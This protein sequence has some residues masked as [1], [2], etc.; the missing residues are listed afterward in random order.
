[1]FN[2]NKYTQLQD[3]KNIFNHV[4][5][6]KY[7]MRVLPNTYTVCG[8]NFCTHICP[9]PWKNKDEILLSILSMYTY[10]TPAPQDQEDH[11]SAWGWW[12]WPS[13]W[14]GLELAE[15]QG[16]P[17]WHWYPHSALHWRFVTLPLQH[18]GLKIEEWLWNTHTISINQCPNTTGQR[19]W[20][21][22][23]L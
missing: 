18:H 22:K 1:M 10:Q 13:R 8:A 19:F 14:H 16:A 6:V 23:N 2:I 7:G 3:Y 21:S 4:V 12:G 11:R 20:D 17:L 9:C 5:F 15:G